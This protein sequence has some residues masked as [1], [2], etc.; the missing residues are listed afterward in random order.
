M[1]VD[2]FTEMEPEVWSDFVWVLGGLAD[3][4]REGDNEGLLYEGE[5]EV[6]FFDFVVDVDVGDDGDGDDDTNPFWGLELLLLFFL[7]G[8]GV[9][10]ECFVD[11]F[12]FVFVVV[13]ELVLLLFWEGEDEESLDG[14]VLGL[15]IEERVF[16]KEEFVSLSLFFKSR[17]GVVTFDSVVEDDWF[18][19]SDF[20]FGKESE[21][22]LRFP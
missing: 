18:F 6:K 11:D 20:S 17:D 9:E 7:K 22:N 15:S 4:V 16:S 10:F 2:R 3:C 14:F 5:E 8:E 12:E 13:A 19:L 21:T 1:E